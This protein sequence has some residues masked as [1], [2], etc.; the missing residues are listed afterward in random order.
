VKSSRLT[1]FQ[2]ARIVVA[3]VSHGLDGRKVTGRPI[4]ICG[5]VN[6]LWTQRLKSKIAVQ[7]INLMT[8][9]VVGGPQLARVAAQKAEDIGDLLSAIKS[10]MEA[11][12]NLWRTVDSFMDFWENWEAQDQ[13]NA[14]SDRQ[15]KDTGLKLNLDDI[16]KMSQSDVTCVMYSLDSEGDARRLAMEAFN[17]AKRLQSDAG[18]M[19]DLQKTMATNLRPLSDK[20]SESSR[21]LRTTDQELERLRKEFQALEAGRT[22][23]SL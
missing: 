14:L 12:Q 23:Y 22:V 13:T 18:R 7:P 16:A 20:L 3:T 15:L 2:D 8:G 4:S 5:T 6:T 17:K 11:V 10:G 9:K 19:Q 1:S 21:R